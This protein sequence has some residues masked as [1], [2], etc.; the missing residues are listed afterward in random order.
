MD[1][2]NL[3]ALL[4]ELKTI[5]LM[6]F[7]IL[8]GMAFIVVLFYSFIR[9]LNRTI[10]VIETQSNEKMLHQELEGLLTRGLAQDAFFIA[11]ENARKRPQ[12]PYILWYLGQAHYQL[13]RY[14]EAKRSFKAVIEIAPNWEA[15]VQPWLEK[16]DA[17]IADA[18]PRVV[19]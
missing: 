14:V 7:F 3:A 10:S 19:N 6:L 12:D 15:T 18:G 8:L 5:R 16:I 9:S 1:T 4:S 13:K 11:S 17:E 2:S